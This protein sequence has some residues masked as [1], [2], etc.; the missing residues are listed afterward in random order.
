M[1]STYR[2]QKNEIGGIMNVMLTPASRES[3]STIYPYHCMGKPPIM[4]RDS[5]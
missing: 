1:K 5:L 3:M 2:P 4:G